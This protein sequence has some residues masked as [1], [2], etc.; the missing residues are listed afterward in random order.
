MK[1]LPEIFA[2]EN[3]Y[4][5]YSTYSRDSKTTESKYE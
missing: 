3:K 5:A 1:I 2:V 4:E